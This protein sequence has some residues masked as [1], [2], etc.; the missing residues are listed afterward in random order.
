MA[1]RI[2]YFK[3]HQPAAFY[4]NYFTLNA[5]AFDASLVVRGKQAVVQHLQELKSRQDLTAKEKDEVTVLEVV[6]EALSRGLHFKPVSLMES[7]AKLFLLTGPNELVPP[8]CA[9]AGLGSTCAE[10]IVAERPGRPFRSQEDLSRRTGANKNVIEI[11]AQHGCLGVL[12]KTDQT[13]LF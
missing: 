12:P 9:L 2:A 8:L 10:R 7:D 1:F 3:V 4:T 6:R 11:L 13:T 5:E